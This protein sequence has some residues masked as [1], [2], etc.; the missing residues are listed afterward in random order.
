MAPSPSPGAGAGVIA[1]DEDDEP[2]E[3]LP[4]G[5]T[6]VGAGSGV[7]MGAG[8]GIGAGSG[9]GTGTLVLLRS[10]QAAR[11]AA[12]NTAASKRELDRIGISLKCFAK[13][14]KQSKAPCSGVS[15][16]SRRVA[17]CAYRPATDAAK[18]GRPWR[19]H[20]LMA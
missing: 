2:D 6:G 12:L 18:P 8:A 13:A 14:I 5:G 16:R 1:G 9:A 15:T 17:A 11:A 20:S 3:L 10:P 7:G 4:G 19:K